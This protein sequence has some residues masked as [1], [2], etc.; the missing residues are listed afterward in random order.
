MRRLKVWA[1]LALYLAIFA[2]L[3]CGQQDLSKPPKILYGRDV[4]AQCRMII[5]DERF[6]AAAVSVDGRIFKFD[7]IGCLAVHEKEQKSRMLKTWARDAGTGGWVEKEKALFVYSRD[8]VTP[9]GYGFAA[10]TASEDAEQ[11]AHEKAGRL[12]TWNELSSLTQE[13]EQF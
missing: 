6:A 7:D 10:F 4:C 1:I 8:L 12:V 2:V 5:D 9:M 3:G 11:W 13:A